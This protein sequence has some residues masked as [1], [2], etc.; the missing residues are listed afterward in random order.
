MSPQVQTLLAL[1]L[2]ALAATGLVWRAIVRRNHPGCGHDC[3]C[4][5]SALRPPVKQPRRP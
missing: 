4:P 2:V 3:S 5:A 1:A